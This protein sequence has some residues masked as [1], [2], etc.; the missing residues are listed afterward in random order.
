MHR[1]ILLLALACAAPPLGAQSV[2][3][4]SARI[5]PQFHSYTVG[6][7]SNLKVSEFAVPLFVLVPL[8]PSFTIDV[9]TSYARSHVEQTVLGKTTTSEISGLTDT[10]I[11]G[12]YVIGTDFIVLTA[13]V[14]IP[15]GRSTV[16]NRQ[17]V[18]A[19]LIGSDF[20]SFPISNMGTGFGGTG[21]IALARP[22]GEWNLGV[23]VSVRR[24]SR[25]RAVRR[26]GGPRSTISRGTSIARRIGIDRPVGTGRATFG[27][28][29]STFGND[30][31]AGSV[32]NTGDRYFSQ[33]DF[34]NTLGAGELTLT[35]WDLFRTTGTLADG[36]A[37]DHENIANAALDVRCARGS[38]MIEPNVEG[39]TWM[40]PGSSTSLMGTF[41]VRSRWRVAG[42]AVM[43]SVGFSVGRL[44]AQDNAVNTTASLT[45]FHATLAI[46]LR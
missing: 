44:A 41:G 6:A 21:G 26:A 9:G 28:T 35:A 1:R 37:L 19:G 38:A 24:S 12:H 7:P 31:L 4:V 20:L 34:D 46:R 32:Y 15:T 5:A 30:N 33:F 29:Y 18:A 11:R 10:Q 45:G 17:V 3:D 36:T 43:P 22:L 2:Y 27:V 8:T 25:I 23:G 13:G 16:R 40:Q 39:R 42:M 14:N